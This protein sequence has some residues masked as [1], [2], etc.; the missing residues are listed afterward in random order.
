MGYP[1]WAMTRLSGDLL[2]CPEMRLLS[3]WTRV[4]RSTISQVSIAYAAANLKYGPHARRAY[5]V[6][7]GPET[8]VIAYYSV[9]C[10]SQMATN[11]KMFS[12]R[13][14]AVNWLNDGVADSQ[15]IS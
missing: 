10:G 4:T 12:N 1:H 5:I 11:I 3:D 15:K 8:Q 14:E 2:F 7:H 9:F 13:S 6:S